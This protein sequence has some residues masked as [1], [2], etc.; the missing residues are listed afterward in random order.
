V[1]T[2]A[3]PGPEGAH[4]AAAC[5]QLFPEGELVVLPSFEAVAGAVA[6]GEVEYGVLPMENTFA[7]PVA[8]T[9]DLLYDSPL[10]IAR[11]TTVAIRHALVGLAPVTREEIRVVRSHPM[12]LDQCRELLA[13]LPWA[14]AIA[15]PTTSGA[16]AL[17]AEGGDRTEVAISSERAAQA[18]GLVVI[19]DDVGDHHEVYTRFV[20][21]S[22]HVRLD[23]EGDEDWRIAFSFVTDHAPGALHRALEPFARHALDLVQLVSRP[24]P[25]TPWRYRFDAVLA[26]HPLD[27]IVNETLAELRAM[28][29]ELRV[30]GSYPVAG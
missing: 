12:A 4:S 1:P 23:R 19:E 5:D 26:G 7:G 13:A 16:A 20:A 9:H 21:V 14:T 11:Q 24:I 30:F 6:R 2:V 3:Y 28:T 29:R 25:K 15:A 27:P 8:P 22:T 17:V 18:H 10:A